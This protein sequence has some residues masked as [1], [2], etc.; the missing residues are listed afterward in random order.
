M[1]LVPI[2]QKDSH[3]EMWC[4]HGIS[5]IGYDKGNV[6]FL[7]VQQVAFVDIHIQQ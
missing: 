4:F 3:N 5:L 6:T 2:M 1:I 7:P